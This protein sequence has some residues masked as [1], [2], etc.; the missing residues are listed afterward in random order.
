MIPKS[1][2]PVVV[3]SEPF[4]SNLIPRTVGML[5]AIG[6]DDETALAANEIDRVRPDWL[7]PHEFKSI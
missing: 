2:N 3:T 7:L 1:Q 4:V 6:L 5:A